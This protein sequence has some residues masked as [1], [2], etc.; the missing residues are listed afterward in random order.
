MPRTSVQ[1]R[2]DGPSRAVAHGRRRGARVRRPLGPAS[3]RYGRSAR[4]S[5]P[6]VSP[7]PTESPAALAPDA[8][9]VRRSY[10]VAPSTYLCTNSPV[11]DEAMER[12]HDQSATAGGQAIGHRVDVRRE[13]QAV[14]DRGSHV[15]RPHEIS[16][17]LVVLRSSPMH[18]TVPASRSFTSVRYLCPFAV[19]VPSIPSRRTTR[20]PFAACPR[21]RMCQA[22][23]QGMR[24]VP[25][26]P[27]T[28]DSRRTSIAK[29]SNIAVK[30][31][32]GSTH[33]RRACSGHFRVGSY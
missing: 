21:S 33:G 4:Q 18:S 30:R 22:S 5:P 17:R 27:S 13:L 9:T 12:R 23:F 20:D 7:C 26:A 16:T 25:F 10:L 31:A 8:A 2:L 28:S 29:R 32:L 19:A 6:T 14:A 24:K 3:R 15:R 11:R 1:K